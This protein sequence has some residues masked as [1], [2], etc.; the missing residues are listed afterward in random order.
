MNDF[1]EIGIDSKKF[2]SGKKDLLMLL[3][4]AKNIIRNAIKQVIVASNN[5]LFRAF[6]N[7]VTIPFLTI[8]TTRITNKIVEAIIPICSDELPT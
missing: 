4:G 3:P 1:T 8:V 6:S 7:V 2:I 5:F